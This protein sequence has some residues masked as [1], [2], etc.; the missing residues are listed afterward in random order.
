MTSVV[1]GRRRRRRMR[2]RASV[3]AEPQHVARERRACHVHHRAVPGAPG[4]PRG[5]LRAR[6]ANDVLRALRV[7][8]H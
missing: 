1:W 2:R 5:P 7:H 6:C 8:H 4:H 3:A